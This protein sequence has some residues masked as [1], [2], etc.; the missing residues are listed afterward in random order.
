M[1]GLKGLARYLARAKTLLADFGRSVL[2]V[3]A[4][5]AP[6]AFATAA[7]GGA[8][9]CTAPAP[10]QFSTDGRDTK[11]S[12]VVTRSHYACYAFEA[13][14]GRTL[15]AKVVSARSNVVFVVYA[16][17]YA[18]TVDDQGPN[19]TGPTLPGAGEDD[20]AVKLSAKLALTGRYLILVGMTRGDAQAFTFSVG[21]Q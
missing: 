7:A 14:A 4:L 17:G 19:V 15:H 5:F 11:L 3:L 20:E 8:P 1:P 18:V 21:L 6:R 10:I 12:N 16:P 9:E 2:C 13:E